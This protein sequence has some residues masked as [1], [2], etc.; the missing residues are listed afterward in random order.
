MHCPRGVECEPTDRKAKTLVERTSGETGTR[1]LQL[2][3]RLASP[4]YFNA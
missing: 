4:D 2:G 3:R 1:F